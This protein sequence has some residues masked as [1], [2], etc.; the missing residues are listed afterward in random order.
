[1]F[2]DGQMSSQLGESVEKDGLSKLGG[3]AEG[4]EEEEE[5]MEGI[6]TSAVVLGMKLGDHNRKNSDGKS[7]MMGLSALGL[8]S[9]RESLEHMPESV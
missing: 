1:M 7:S 8:E 6:P 5:G 4:E 2:G 3:D 9:H